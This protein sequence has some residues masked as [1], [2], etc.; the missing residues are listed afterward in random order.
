M[1]GYVQTKN[2]VDERS[3]PDKIGLEFIEVEEHLFADLWYSQKQKNLFRSR[4]NQLHLNVCFSGRSYVDMSV[5]HIG[6]IGR[7][8]L[9]NSYTDVYKSI[10]ISVATGGEGAIK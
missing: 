6:K 1:I 3:L 8:N 10:E 2:K 5:S 7:M 4:L 9:N